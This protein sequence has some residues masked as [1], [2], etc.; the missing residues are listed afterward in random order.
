MAGHFID[1]GIPAT[2]LLA[3]VLIAK[4]ADLL[5]QYRQEKTFAHASFII[6]RSTLADWVGACGVVFL[7]VWTGKLV[8]NDFGGYKA[9][10]AAGV[11]EIAMHVASSSICMREKRAT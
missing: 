7:G 1:K 3:Q 9:S 5:Q 2:G 11:T 4:H 8:C 6:D 10:F